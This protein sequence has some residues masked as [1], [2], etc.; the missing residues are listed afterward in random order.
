MVDTKFTDLTEDTSPATSDIVA[1]VDDPTGTAVSKKVQLSNLIKGM[2]I[3]DASNVTITTNSSGEIL[4]WNGSAWINQ[5][6][7]EAGIGANVDASETDKG[8]LELATQ[9]ETDTGTDDESPLQN[10]PGRRRN[11]HS[12]V[13]EACPWRRAVHRR[14]RPQ[15]C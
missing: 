7:A 11:F 9:T 15:C 2:S 14:Y 1:T 6:L 4:V 10:P 13:C 5:T 3:D 8:I 12:W